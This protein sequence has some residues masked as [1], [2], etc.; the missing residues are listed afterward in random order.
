MRPCFAAP[1][2]LASLVLATASSS[3]AERARGPRD[4]LFPGGAAEAA[5]A[6]LG[7]DVAPASA[8]GVELALQARLP[9][10]GATTVRFTQRYQ[11]L[12]VVGAM[13]A[14][15]VGDDGRIHLAALELEPA[16]TVG[17]TPAVPATS[18]AAVAAATAGVGAEK[19]G[20][21]RL[22][23]LPGGE[24]AP[25][26]RLVWEVDV[27]SRPGGERFWVDAVRGTVARREVLARS[28]LGRVYT[29]SSKD[30]PTPTDEPLLDL[31]PSEPQRL[32]AYNGRLAVYQYES[33]GQQAPFVGSQETVPNV[34]ADF[35]YDPPLSSMD[36]SDHFAV[37][38]TYYHIHRMREF[39]GTTLG[40]D[41][42]S[43]T[44][45]LGVVANA[46][47]SG[48]P[49]DN[50]FYSPG[51]MD[52]PSHPNLIAIGQGNKDFSYDSDVFMH[53]F[54]HYASRNAIGYNQGQFGM[55]AYGIS[56]FG[57]SIDEG[58]SDYF[59]CTVNGDADMG[60]AVLGNSARDLDQDD[61][62]RCP[63]GLF[64]EVHED[65]KI[66]GNVAWKIRKL[67]GPEVAD[68][69]VW[70]G[71]SMLLSGTSLQ[72]FAENIV[73]VGEEMVTSGKITAEQLATI[74]GYF[75][76]RGLFDCGRVLSLNKEERE[77]GQ[78]GLELLG[79]FF[80]AGCNQ[81]KNFIELS[82]PFHFSY[83]PDPG[84]K[85]ITFEVELD[86]LFGGGS[87]DWTLYVRK[88][89]TVS[90]KSSF[91]GFPEVSKY[92]FVFDGFSSTSN[93]FE[94]GEGTEH[95]L[96]PEST[97][98]AVLVH[99][100]CPY[101]RLTL[102]AYSDDGAAGQAGSPAAGADGSGGSA[103]GQAG[104]AGTGGAP[105]LG[106]VGGFGGAGTGGA[107]GAAIEGTL[108]P[109]GGSCGC[110][111]AGTQEPPGLLAGLALGLAA[112]L[113]RRRAR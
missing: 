63:E 55:D 108:S 102:N 82:S 40:V 58:I 24:D 105:G 4:R 23:V 12:P 53:E 8:R 98:Y 36:P 85:R 34:G 107:P 45:S 71:F 96:D 59:A 57:G 16:L 94:I 42:T 43:A 6:Y 93:S 44:W 101:T 52:Q 84:A 77:V 73:A 29:I 38:N 54:T 17:T 27:T 3:A 32:T 35:L 61:G 95:P 2:L 99:K 51:G 91:N 50:A 79:Q 89:K 9:G 104:K 7:S 78:F 1:A 19:A 56:A 74:K 41:M 20:T 28:V 21:P 11:G 81:L 14:V 49:M 92:D 46:R 90:F 62:R 65:G 13:A 64:G 86:K 80:G 83:Q 72:D 111:A 112:L 67:L 10:P 22:A 68:Q 48:A 47:D 31:D 30:T 66:I 15:R 37:V 26:G 5:Q 33:G 97:Y 75:D 106:G 88:G 18:A 60:S 76:A 113:R 25:G 39:F 70:G 100:N 87:L 103:A 110:R 69:L 109:E